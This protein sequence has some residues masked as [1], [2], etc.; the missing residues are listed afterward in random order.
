[1]TRLDAALKATG[2]VLVRQK[3]HK[4]YRLP[5]GQTYVLSS[6][7]SNRRAEDNAPKLLDRVA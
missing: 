3:K 7:M 1:M 4:V 2:A 5:N 6:T